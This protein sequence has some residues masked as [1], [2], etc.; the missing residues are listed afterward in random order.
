MPGGR[1]RGSS[2]RQVTIVVCSLV[3]FEALGGGDKIG[4][5]R[6]RIL[7]YL[8]GPTSR[9]DMPLLTEPGVN[10]KLSTVKFI[11]S[12]RCLLHGL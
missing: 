5:V 4:Y 12:S 1:V 9:F 10:I 6:N 2:Q 11:W 8:I 7:T 3:A